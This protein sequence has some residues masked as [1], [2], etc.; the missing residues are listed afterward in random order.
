MITQLD[1]QCIGQVAKHCDNEKLC[2]AIEESKD[3]DLSSLF[4]SNLLIEAL[5]NFSSTD[6]FWVNLWNGGVF[7]SACGKVKNHFGLKRIWVYYAQSRYILL[8]GSND[9]ATGFKQKTNDFSLP[10]L[11]KELQ[12]FEN[13]YRNMGFEA[14]SLTANFICQNKEK[15]TGDV[16]LDCK[17]DC[18]CGSEKCGGKTKN[19]LGIRSSII[20][21]NSYDKL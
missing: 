20:K 18:S 8:N 21:K 10:I 3:F 15:F 11:F 2:I 12:V 16:N 14:F 4:C 19:N 1:F 17:N 13:K 6:S 7:T 9:T 5:A